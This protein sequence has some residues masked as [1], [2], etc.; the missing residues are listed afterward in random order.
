MGSLRP[1]F[2]LAHP[3]PAPWLA[4]ICLITVFL[5]PSL[6]AHAQV[7][8]A[9]KTISAG[10]NS[11]PLS[12]V[13]RPVGEDSEPMHGSATIGESSVPV[14]S[15]PVRGAGTRSMLSGPVSE[16]SQGTMPHPGS[17]AGGAVAEASAGAVKHDLDKPLG[18]RISEPLRE[19]GRLQD[20][21]RALRT[22]AAASAAAGASR[23]V[24]EAPLEPSERELVP[25]LH[26]ET[27]PSA[28]DADQPPPAAAPELEPAQP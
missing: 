28:H 9:D 11:G 15:G 26:A 18:D 4:C 19:L 5:L 8:D 22:Q 27:G 17:L 24:V 6:A 7:R 1:P 21:L 23:P 14:R 12:D 25:E 13:S 2:Q 20:Q 3:R 10:E 16:V